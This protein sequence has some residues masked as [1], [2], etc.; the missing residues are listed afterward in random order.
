MLWEF[1]NTPA[2]LSH[3]IASVLTAFDASKHVAPPDQENPLPEN[4]VPLLPGLKELRAGDDMVGELPEGFLYIGGLSKPIIP[5]SIAEAAVKF[6]TAAQKG[7]TK[8][9]KQGSNSRTSA[10]SH[11]IASEYSNASFHADFTPSNSDG[12]GD[13]LAF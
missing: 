10:S 5:P 4:I 11:S 13:E 6:T 12:S 3:P 8:G 2:P 1:R 9:S 7:K